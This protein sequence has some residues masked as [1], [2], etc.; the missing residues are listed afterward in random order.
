MKNIKKTLLR[1][2]QAWMWICTISFTV[3]VF[4][5]YLEFDF[6]TYFFEIDSCLDHGGA[7]DEE[8]NR[9]YYSEEELLNFSKNK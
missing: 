4:I 7:W 2:W 3:I 6:G 8:N 1:L 5:F 9:C